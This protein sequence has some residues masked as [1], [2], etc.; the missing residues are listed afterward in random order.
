MPCVIVDAKC[1][2]IVFQ[3][4]PSTHD[5][6]GASVTGARLLRSDRNT[7]RSGGAAYFILHH[8][9]QL[10]RFRGTRHGGVDIHSSWDSLLQLVFGKL[11]EMDGLH[12]DIAASSP[13]AGFNREAQIEGSRPLISS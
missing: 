1:S 7:N 3:D 6:D 9:P 11:G 4:V 13:P 12:V 2:E 8:Y 5:L 10:G